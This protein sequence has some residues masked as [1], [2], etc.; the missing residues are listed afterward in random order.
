MLSQLFTRFDKKCV[1][2]EV[3]KVHTIGD[4]YVVLGYSGISLR[5]PLRECLN[6][7]KMARD[8]VE[9]IK[10]ENL[11]HGSDLN[12]RIGIHTGDV[13]GGVIGTNTVRYD[14]WGPDVLIAN[15]MESSGQPGFI[16]V[17]EDTRRLLLQNYD[18]N[19][20]FCMNSEVIIE[21]LRRSVRCF[22]LETKN[23]TC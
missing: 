9:I 20:S 1:E 8:M 22:F 16:N 23:K 17:S 10:D 21:S 19:F 7:V 2:N 3:Y 5:D 18:E 15:K 6:V 13:I 11:I 14:I 4:C 12:M